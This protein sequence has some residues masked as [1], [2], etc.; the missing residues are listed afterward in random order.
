M[1]EFRR[2]TQFPIGWFDQFESEL[3][4]QEQ[5]RIAHESAH[6]LLARVR[7]GADPDVVDR[8]LRLASEDGIDT[9]AELWAHSAAHSLPG[10]L[11]RIHVVH[12]LVVQRSE[13]VTRWY[14]LGAAAIGTIDPIIAGAPS[15][16]SPD[17]IRELSELILRGVFVGDFAH[18]IERS[19]SF[20]RV[21]GRGCLIE[22]DSVEGADE[23][24]AAELVRRAARL[25][26]MGRELTECAAM[27]RRDA[28]D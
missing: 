10:A 16:A 9:V 1:S 20:V 6:A 23:R 4:P 7:E 3:D 15:P 14:E 2:P 22:A 17:E 18:A 26:Q 11:W 19:A 5:Y 24:R 25:T 28:L 8:I 21:V 13:D 27:W 12:A